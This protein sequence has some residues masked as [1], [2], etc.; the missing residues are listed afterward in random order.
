MKVMKKISMLLVVLSMVVFTG[1]S[2]VVATRTTFDVKKTKLSDE[3]MLDV[4]EKILTEE[5]MKVVSQ[6]STE[7]YKVVKAVKDIEPESNQSAADQALTIGVDYLLGRDVLTLF[8]VLD[9]DKMYL[10]GTLKNVKKQLLAG[11][12]VSYKNM[13]EEM[14]T[15]RSLDIMN[16][17]AKRIKEDTGLSGRIWNTTGKL[18]SEYKIN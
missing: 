11:D 9:D 15:E 17:I 1:C 5:G 6:E 2:N 13:T 10:Y 14:H 12:D 4:V 16:K 8:F 18:G 3:Q 7:K